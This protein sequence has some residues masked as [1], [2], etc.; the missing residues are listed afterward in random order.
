[1]D[2]KVASGEYQVP[3]WT[4]FIIERNPSWTIARIAVVVVAVFI[5]FKF[6]L[7]PIRVTGNS[8][9][10]TYNH[11]GIRFVN[12]LAYLNSTPQRGDVVAVQFQGEE[13]LLLKRVV[14]VPGD[15]VE[16]REGEIYVGGSRLDE[17]YA[18]GRIPAEKGKGYAEFPPLKLGSREYVVTGDN[19]PVSEHF[20]IFAKQII[21]KV[22]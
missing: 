13:V 22:L 12:K 17:P 3:G 19:R 10:P 8:M 1:M 7:V 5:L 21:G 18:N 11:G 14:A 6:V 2:N 4:R 20:Q 16:V 15:T 9:A